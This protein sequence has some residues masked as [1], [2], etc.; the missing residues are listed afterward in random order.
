MGDSMENKGGFISPK[1][2]EEYLRNRFRSYMNRFQLYRN[3]NTKFELD[4]Y[5]HEKM[6]TINEADEDLCCTD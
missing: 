2:R 5:Q 4:I 6:I 3:D 1:M